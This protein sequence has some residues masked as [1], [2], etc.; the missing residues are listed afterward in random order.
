MPYATS[1]DEFQKCRSSGSCLACQAPT[2]T[3]LYCPALPKNSRTC[4]GHSYNTP[5]QPYSASLCSAKAL[6]QERWAKGAGPRA[7]GQ[8]R[9]AKGAGSRVLGQG[10][11]VK[12]AGPRAGL[13]WGWA[14]PCWHRRPLVQRQVSLP[15][16]CSP[17][18]N[19]YTRS[20]TCHGDPR[21]PWLQWKIPK[22]APKRYLSQTPKRG[23]SLPRLWW[24][25]VW[26]GLF[27]CLPEWLQASGWPSYSLLPTEHPW[28]S[29]HKNGVGTIADGRVGFGIAQ[30]Q[31][32]AP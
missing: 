13:R 3:S 32:T 22:A 28:P 5:T 11:W 27:C 15:S 19:T 20:Q 2:T 6:G 12:G 26:V 24:G 21:Q 25:Q 1:R 29:R 17:V 4:K 9:W 31:Q 18:F 30:K 23:K 7:L 10:R 16:H 8:G 14:M